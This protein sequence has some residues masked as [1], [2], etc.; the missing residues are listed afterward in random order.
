IATRPVTTIFP[1]ESLSEAVRRMGVRDIGQLPVVERSSPGHPIGLLRRNDIVRA[2][3]QAMLK[4]MEHER[5]GPV[6][7]SELRGTQIVEAV[8]G[9]KSP[10]AGFRIAELQL[11]DTALII[12]VEREGQTVIPHGQTELVRGDRLMLLVRND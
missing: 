8:I 1:D 10:L 7:P 4:R 11:P 9:A 6:Q 5:K 2:Y 3:S 12:A